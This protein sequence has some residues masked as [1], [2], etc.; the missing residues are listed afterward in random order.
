MKDGITLHISN[1]MKH[2]I[3]LNLKDVAK[4]RKESNRWNELIEAIIDGRVIPVIGAD[5]LT[6]AP[7]D[8]CVESTNHHQQLLDVLAAVCGIEEKPKSFSQLIHNREFK[9]VTEGESTAIYSLIPELID[10]IKAQGQIKPNHLLVKLL[11]SKLFPFVITTSFSPVVEMVMQQIWTD[12]PIRVLQYQNDPS[13]DL[14]CGVGDIESEKDL[15]VPTV[16][17]MFGKYSAEPHRYVVSDL[18]MMEFCKSWLTGGNK[19]PRVLSE[20]L[21]KKYLLVLGNNYSDWLFRFIWYSLRN[22]P[23]MM[24]SSLI[25]QDRL[26]SSLLVFLEQLQTFIERDPNHMIA[27]IERRV[28]E[29]LKSIQDTAKDSVMKY[30]VFISYS[31][32]DAERVRLLVDALRSEGLRVWFD[33]T[34][35]PGGADWKTSIIHGIRATRLFVP[36]LTSNVEREY[37][38]PHEYRDEWDVAAEISRKLGGRSFIWPLAEKGFDFD[39]PENRLPIEFQVKNAT[40]FDL[41]DDLG[42]FATKIRKEVENLKHKENE[43]KNGL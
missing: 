2:N 23:D 18:D 37:L 5:F 21:K 40:W 28:S 41:A 38:F 16:Y 12:K 39:R 1:T 7:G 24:H 3:N 30:D 6:E 32:K 43:I 42:S 27:E 20:A 34:D 26:E 22:T 4:R 10:Q 15:K 31:R 29:R 36:V 33:E 14:K 13:R 25:L 19:V 9:D 17:Y 35:I 11:S 8:D